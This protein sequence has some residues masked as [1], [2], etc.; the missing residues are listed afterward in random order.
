MKYV[1]NPYLK[2]E[3]KSKLLLDW[4]LWGPLLFNLLLSGSLAIN[5][6]DKGGLFVLV[7]GIFWLGSIAI[8]VNSDLLGGKMYDIILIYH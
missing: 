2:D 6:Y 7:F 5:N 1:L 4:D 8:Y 3:L